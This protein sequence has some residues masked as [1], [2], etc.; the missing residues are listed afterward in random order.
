[1]PV[2]K[3]THCAYVQIRPHSSVGVTH[4][5]AQFQVPRKESSHGGTADYPTV[6]SLAAMRARGEHIVTVAACATI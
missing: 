2:A 6:G 1:M 3:T 4:A 5:G